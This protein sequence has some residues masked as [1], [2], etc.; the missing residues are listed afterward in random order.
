MIVAQ[1]VFLGRNNSVD[2]QYPNE[3]LH[4]AYSVGVGSRCK[5]G[6]NGNDETSPIS[7]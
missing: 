1:W 3:A 7:S 2:L 4:D 6:E 5:L